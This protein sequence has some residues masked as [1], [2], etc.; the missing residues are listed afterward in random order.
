MAEPFDTRVDEL[1]EKL[2]QKKNNEL[3]NAS[4]AITMKE[5]DGNFGTE[6]DAWWIRVFEQMK[7]AKKVDLLQKF[8]HKFRAMIPLEFMK[9]NKQP[10]VDT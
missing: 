4:I 3:R 2:M 10:S 1:M 9:E 6:N 5:I 8:V 7:R